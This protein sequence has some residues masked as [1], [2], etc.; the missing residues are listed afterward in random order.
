MNELLLLITGVV[1]ASF[2]L[3]G[4]KLGKERLYSV[5][6]IFLILVATVGAKIVSFFGHETNTGNI[7]YASTFLATYFLIERYGRREGTFSIWMGIIAVLFF[8]VLVQI[9]ISL[10]GSPST[11]PLNDALSIAFGAVPRVALASL[12]AYAL[13]QSL[14]VYLYL[15]LKRRMQGAYLW[16]R[17]NISNAV[18]QLFDSVVFFMIAFW[19]VV[20]YARVWDLIL[21]GFMIKVVYMM[22]ASLLLYLNTIEEEDDGDGNVMITLRA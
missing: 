13:S 16:L 3:A 8:S 20:P 22:I 6:I 21:T 12:C 7:F 10:T 15:L 1:S 4:W 19:G 9:T 17:A 11:A 14:N 2:V 18:A 5:I